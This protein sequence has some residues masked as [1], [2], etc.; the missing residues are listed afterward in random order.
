MPNDQTSIPTVTRL[1]IGLA[2]I[3]LTLFAAG[4]RLDNGRLRLLGIVAVAVAWLM[5]LY[6]ARSMSD[7]P[8]DNQ[9]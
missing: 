3:G 8:P 2:I 6:K 7:A 5:R 9:Q 4:I 1:K